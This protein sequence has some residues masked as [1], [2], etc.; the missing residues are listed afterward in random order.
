L[1]RAV[2]RSSNLSHDALPRQ[3]QSLS[4]LGP[5]SSS[6][7]ESSRPPEAEK[8]TWT[9]VSEM[10]EANVKVAYR[11]ASSMSNW[12]SSFISNLDPTALLFEDE[13][14]DYLDARCVTTSR[15]ARCSERYA[16][17][18]VSAP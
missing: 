8:D 9:A 14:D 16:A 13:E 3:A 5:S 4:D 11:Y 12:A 18:V 1:K 17:A 6:P 2:F 10:M 15:M 7:W